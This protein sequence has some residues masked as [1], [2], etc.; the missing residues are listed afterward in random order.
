MAHYVLHGIVGVH[1]AP[2]SH[3]RPTAP[4][5]QRALDSDHFIAFIIYFSRIFIYDQTFSF[6]PTFAIRIVFAYVRSCMFQRSHV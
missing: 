5:V 4:I 1:I 3:S 2:P 6:W